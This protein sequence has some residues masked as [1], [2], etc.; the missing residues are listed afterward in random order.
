MLSIKNISKTYN[1]GVK[2]LNSVSIDIPKGMFGLLGPNGAGK[3]SLMRTIATL[4]QADSGSIQFDDIDVLSQPNELRQRLGYLPQDFGVYPRVSAY[5]LLD[6]LAILK[7]LKNKAERKEVVDGLLAHTNLFQHRKKAV[8]GFSGGMRQRFGIAQALI[9]DPDLL[10][11]DEPTAGLDPEERNR[12]HNLLVTL[13][14]DKVIILSTHIV[15]DVS[16]LCSNMAVLGNGEILLQGNPLEITAG[17]NGQ[18]W[19]KTVSVEEAVELEQS[20]PI[21]S[22]RLFAG[23]TVVNVIADAA[24]EGFEATP[25]TLE[26]VYFSTLHASRNTSTNSSST[27]QAA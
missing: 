22:K 5:E 23:R 20:L 16:E 1:N 15:D 11:V 18:I 19:R 17:L 3:S 12:F 26:D 9:G 21:I 10:I 14:E 27:T 2:A 13:G 8:S 24:P 25:A 4:Q 6:H 7:G